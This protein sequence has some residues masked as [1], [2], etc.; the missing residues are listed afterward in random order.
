MVEII[1]PGRAGVFVNRLAVFAI[2]IAIGYLGEQ[3]HLYRR[4]RLVLG[5]IWIAECGAQASATKITSE[6]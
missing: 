1:G 5:G 4:L 3:F 6:T 2:I